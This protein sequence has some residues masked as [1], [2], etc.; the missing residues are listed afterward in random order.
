MP[1]YHPKMNLPYPVDIGRS[2]ANLTF[3]EG[4]R[5]PRDAPTYGSIIDGGSASA[6]PLPRPQTRLRACELGAVPANS[7]LHLRT[8]RHARKFTACEFG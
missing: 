8:H 5:L 4:K 1:T 2:D 7:P 6:N 3:L